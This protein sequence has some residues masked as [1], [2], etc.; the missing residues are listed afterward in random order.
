MAAPTLTDGISRAI[1]VIA[2]PSVAVLGLVGG[3]R[4]VYDA[5]T[6]GIVY[7]G[8]T[9]LILL[10]IYTSAKYWNTGYTIGFVGFGTLIWFGIPGIM[11]KLIPSLFADLS[12]LIVLLFL[13]AV[14]AMI[15]DKW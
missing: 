14:G 3:T 6:A 15:R 5:Q 13:I 4:V 11:P 9:G 1:E 2:V 8:I 12:K 10:G 7:L